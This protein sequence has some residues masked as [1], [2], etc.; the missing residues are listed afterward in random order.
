VFFKSRLNNT[1]CCK[2]HQPMYKAKKRNKK[3]TGL[4]L[5]PLIFRLNSQLELLYIQ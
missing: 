4:F 3:F 2:K 1:N 5:S